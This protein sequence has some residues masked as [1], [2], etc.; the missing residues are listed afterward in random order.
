MK[1]VRPRRAGN[2]NAWAIGRKRPGGFHVR[3]VVW[4]RLLAIEERR[5]G[6]Q[7]RRA[8]IFVDGDS[9]DDRTA[10]GKPA[11]IL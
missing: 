5:E 9:S 3:R 8:I 2:C 11:R 4:G 6:E 10:R 1:H 7:I